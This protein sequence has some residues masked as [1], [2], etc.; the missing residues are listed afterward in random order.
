MHRTATIISSLTRVNRMHANVA[1]GN[2]PL[3]QRFVDSKWILDLSC[4]HLRL[5]L[6]AKG[7]V[8]LLGGLGLLP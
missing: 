2:H 5:F 1:L 6:T 7:S 3:G 8:A 4:T